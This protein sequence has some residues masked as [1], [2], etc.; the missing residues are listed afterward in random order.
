M[1][2]DK[3][4]KFEVIKDVGQDN[5]YIVYENGAYLYTGNLIECNALISLR[6]KQY[7]KKEEV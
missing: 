4:N 7:I 3:R 2:H 5:I 6:E 1:S